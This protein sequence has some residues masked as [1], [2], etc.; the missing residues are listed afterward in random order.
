[1]FLRSY[2][3]ANNT[4]SAKSAEYVVASRASFNPQNLCN[5][6]IPAVTEKNEKQKDEEDG[7]G[8]KSVGPPPIPTA[9]AVPGI[10]QVSRAD[11][12]GFFSFGDNS[13]L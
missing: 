13:R 5:E 2:S 9:S 1:M 3:S 11:S 4:I 8:E 12:S 7:G 6:D 10:I